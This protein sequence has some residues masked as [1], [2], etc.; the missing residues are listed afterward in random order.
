MAPPQEGGE[1]PAELRVEFP[2]LFEDAEAL[3]LVCP[4]EGELVEFGSTGKVL[5]FAWY[6]FE[7]T[8]EEAIASAGALLLCP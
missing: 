5:G 7:V 8:P 6:E 1:C 3:L 4:L 2:A